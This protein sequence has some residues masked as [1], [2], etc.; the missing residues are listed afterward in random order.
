MG[1]PHAHRGAAGLCPHPQSSLKPGGLAQV[2]VPALRRAQ[3]WRE[4]GKAKAKSKKV[5]LS[6]WC[7]GAGPLRCEGCGSSVSQEWR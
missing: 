2:Q 4:H 1:H 7:Q 3:S 5:S 6:S